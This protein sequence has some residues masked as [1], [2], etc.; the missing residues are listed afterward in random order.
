M[1]KAKA[2]PSPVPAP[3]PSEK[4]RE[5][6]EAEQDLARYIQV[7]KELLA[8]LEDLVTRLEQSEGEVGDKILEARLS[9]EAE[10]PAGI[11]QEHSRIWLAVDTTRRALRSA[12]KAKG[13]AQANI[14]VARAHEKRREAGTLK[15]EARARLVITNRLL[16]EL[17]AHEGAQYH[18]PLPIHPSGAGY[19]VN[20]PVTKSQ[21][22]LLQAAGLEEEARRLEEE[23]SRVRARAETEYARPQGQ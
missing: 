5:V 14:L 1:S 8:E 18:P 2:T 16:E 7:E 10:D 21:E 12:G 13:Y 4:P 9:P 23:A 19:A 15:E 3:T 11:N 22:I 20:T 6:L 17:K